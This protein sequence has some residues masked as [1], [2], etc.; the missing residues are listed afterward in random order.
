MSK[1]RCYQ[2]S[3]VQY[4]FTFTVDKDGLQKP[5]CFLC[6][7]VMSNGC[8]KPSKLQEHLKSFH[9][10]NVDDARASFEI[11]RARFQSKGTIVTHGFV[12]HIKPALEA[13][14]KVALRISKEKKP[15]TI[16][17]TLIKPCALDMVELMC[18]KEARHKI[19][20]IPLSNDTIHD[21]IRDMSEDVL[22]QVIEQIKAS[23]GKISVQLDE[24][25]DVS[26]CSQLLVFVR[27]VHE[28]TIKEEFLFCEPLTQMARASDVMDVVNAFF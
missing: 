5:Q 23:P 27:Y 7:K 8:M 2:E 6:S 22:C 3:Y 12:P 20:H 26:N 9:A 10:S 17:E 13:S 19:S 25:T 28:Y 15:H 24:T 1:K 16:A 14:Y 11:K 18:G 4:G 21:R